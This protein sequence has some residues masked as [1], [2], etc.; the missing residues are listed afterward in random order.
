MKREMAGGG[1][2]G[3]IWEDPGT[4]ACETGITALEPTGHGA[5]DLPSE[6]WA[7]VLAG[8]EG[9]RLRGFVRQLLGSERPKQFCRITGSRSMLRHT[10]DR[11]ARVVDP[12]RIV[13]VITAGQEPYLDE[14]AG[15]GVPGTVLVQPE[16]KET[17][18]GLILPLLWIARRAPGAT[19]A[20]LP[21]DHF[22]W[23]EE[24]FA[25][26][27]R[28]ALAAAEYWPDRLLLLGA[29]AEGPETGYGWIAPGGVLAQGSAPE[30][31]TVRRFWEKPDR[32]TAA[33]LF[34][35]GYFWNTLVLAGRLGAYLRLAAAEAPE[36]LGPLGAI[37]ECLGTSMEAAALRAAYAR[38]PRTNLS[39]VLLA[40]RPEALMVLAVRGLGWS[41]WGDAERILGSLR[42]FNRRPGWLPADAQ[43]RAQAGACAVP[44]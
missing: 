34:A 28:T 9:R 4:A 30:L 25:T 13:T 29:E 32:Q 16:N 41:D 20:V 31:H 6:A 14:E 19:V 17:A 1:A 12:D 33:R 11:A 3:A 37:A 24:R 42:R 43:G 15:H 27:V 5:R 7:V 39:H 22:V 8:G 2:P 10:W 21:A 35:C 44:A 18:P 23:D 38:I 26:A 36:A 40:R